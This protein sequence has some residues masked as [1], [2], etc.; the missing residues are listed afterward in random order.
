MGQ[1]LLRWL[2]VFAAAMALVTTPP[3]VG[4]AADDAPR[5]PNVVIIFADDLGYGDLG[6]YGSD[7]PTPNLD[8]MAAEG[9]RMTDF[10]TAQAVCSASRAALLTGCY[11]NRIGILGALFPGHRHGIHAAEDTIAD[12]LKRRGYAA[13]AF[14]KWHLG[15]H[16]PFLPTAHGFDEYF[17]LPYSNDMRPGEQKRTD[18]PP[19]PLID[20]TEAVETDPDQSTLTTRYTERALR[21]IDANKDGPFF[22]YVPHTMPHV[23]LYVSDKFRGKSPRG[24][25]GDVIMEIDWSVGQI[26]DRLKSHGLDDH[27]LVVFTADNGPWLRFGDHG[28][29]AG[30]L[31][32][33]KGTTFEGGVRV[34]AIFRFPGRIPG[35]RTC[36]EPAMTIDL[37]PTVARLAGAELSD[38]RAID[39]KDIWP[40]LAGEPGATSPHEALYFYWD[41][42]LEAVRSGKWKLHFPHDYQGAPKP[43]AGGTPGPAVNRRIELSLFDLSADVGE[44]TDVAAA[45]PDVVQRLTELAE[46]ARADLGDALTRRPGKNVRPPGRVE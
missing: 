23:P 38:E 45:H 12:V 28:G 5:P 1:S 3:P 17:G 21:F 37:L 44:T 35:G 20:G 25:Y 16:A 15:H 32:E 27:T 42:G 13:G 29:S 22:L 24:L 36:A 8:R 4:A 26:L 14:G 10:Y 6:C 39:G 31:R 33:G 19:L 34:P 18:F 9:V 43:G 41:Q 11:P 46:R 30:P 7:V 40:L 2:F